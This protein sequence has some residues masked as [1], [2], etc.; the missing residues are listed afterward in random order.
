MQ[1]SSGTA[2]LEGSSR[3]LASSMDQL[4]ANSTSS[5]SN[6]DVGTAETIRKVELLEVQLKR[7][8]YLTRMHKYGEEGGAEELAV[9]SKQC[10]ESSDY[11]P[12]NSIA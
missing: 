10:K 12:S 2:S 9:V 1:A 7:L 6:T 11:S 5:S 4:Q 3:S 8:L